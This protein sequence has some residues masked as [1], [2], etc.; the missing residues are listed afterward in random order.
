[1]LFNHLVGAGEKRGWHGDAERLGA[2]EVDDQLNFGGLL[3]RQVSWLVALENPAGVDASQT[4][5][6]RKVAAVAHQAA[7]C[8][9]FAKLVDRGHPMAE[10]QYGELF[11]SAVEECVGANDEPAYLQ[12]RQAC[13]G[14]FEV[15]FG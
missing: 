11:V 15:A 10:R 13:E 3:D 9:E 4:M 2:L 14:R 1:M 8:G 12:L 5:K 7:S 6:F